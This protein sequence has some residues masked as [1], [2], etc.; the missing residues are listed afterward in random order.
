MMLDLY[1]DDDAEGLKNLAES[2][3]V[4]MVLC[5]ACNPQYGARIEGRHAELQ[6]ECP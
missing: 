4:R 2:M 5:Q 1:P 6:S 3:K